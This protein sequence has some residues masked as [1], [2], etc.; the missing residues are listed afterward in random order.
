LNELTVRRAYSARRRV[1]G[2][3]TAVGGAG[4]A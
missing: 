2:V 4:T 3:G 1:T